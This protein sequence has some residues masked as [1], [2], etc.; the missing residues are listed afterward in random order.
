MFAIKPL[1]RLRISTLGQGDISPFLFR[2]PVHC[3]LD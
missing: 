2:V 3:G 1:E